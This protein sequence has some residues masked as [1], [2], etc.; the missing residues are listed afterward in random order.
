MIKAVVFDLDNT[1]I[2]F[3][4]AKISSCEASVN[5][6][7]KAGLTIDRTKAMKILFELY[8]KY[9]I[10]YSKVFQKFL[11]QTMGKI[12]MRILSAAIVAYRNVQANYRKPYAGTVDV[13][14]ELKARGYKLAILSDATSLKAWIRL[15]EM[16]IQD[17]FDAVVTFSDTRK[18]KPH[19][20]PFRKVLRKLRIKPEEILFVGDMPHRDIKGA[21][22]MGMKTALAVYG[23][24]A[25]SKKHMRRNPP[26]HLLNSVSDVIDV[27]K[28]LS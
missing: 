19:Q 5:A 7:I 26:D 3:M 6:M 17:Y 25:E 11:L 13:L 21:K 16:G 27:L 24:G 15:T 20:L 9:G 14:K 1:L 8:A 12:D 23:I 28:A 10:E 2:D 22:S 18:R 4:G